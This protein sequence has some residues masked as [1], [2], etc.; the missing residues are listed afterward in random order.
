MSIR[1]KHI[2][3]AVLSA[4]FIV[5]LIF[6]QWMEVA[7]KQEEAGIGVRHVSVPA[8]STACVQCHQ[9]SSPGI[10]DHWKGST[11]AVKGVGCVECHQAEKG[12]ADAFAR[13]RGTDWMQEPCRSCPL[14][15]QEEDWG[16]CRCQALR[17]TGDAAAT[18]PVCRFSPHH[19][20]VVASRDAAQTDEFTP[21]TTRRPR[22]RDGGSG[23][24][25]RRRRPAGV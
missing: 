17:L 14:G 22:D 25:S 24:L 15:R 23:D 7:R 2:L 4:T 9:Q 6:V 12:D 11:H 8:S 16:G 13:F 21:R 18:D 19:E 3:I 5:S 10:I 1:T 20:A